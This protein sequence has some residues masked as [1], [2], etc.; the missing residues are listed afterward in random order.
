MSFLSYVIKE[1]APGVDHPVIDDIRQ[2]RNELAH[3]GNSEVD[4]L[5]FQE[6]FSKIEKAVELLFARWPDKQN[7]WRGILQQI[8]T[9]PIG[10]V[11]VCA[12]L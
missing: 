10:C 5:R 1:M 11:C 8:R 3:N 9:D 6:Y 4:K 12:I 2:V 7:E